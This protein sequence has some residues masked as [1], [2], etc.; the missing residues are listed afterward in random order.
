MAKK[1]HVLSK[2][3]FNFRKRCIFL[4]QD[5]VQLI[6]NL[7]LQKMKQHPMEG[8]LCRIGTPSRFIATPRY[9]G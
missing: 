7:H 1:C 4:P 6:K 8:V 2:T 5:T 3:N 9:Y